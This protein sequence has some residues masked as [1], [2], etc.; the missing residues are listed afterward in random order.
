MLCAGAVDS[1]EMDIIYGHEG[2][3]SPHR[4]MV[5]ELPSAYR[6]NL[7]DLAVVNA[8][9]SLS[10]HGLM[11]FVVSVV[12]QM[13]REIRERAGFQKNVDALTIIVNFLLAILPNHHTTRYILLNSP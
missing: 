13:M 9:L 10:L 5:S 6:N 8:F 11:P 2:I 3:G 4:E 12:N 7:L 1:Q